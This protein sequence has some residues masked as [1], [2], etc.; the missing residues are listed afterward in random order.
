MEVGSDASS[1]WNARAIDMLWLGR[2]GKPEVSASDVELGAR[3]SR[4]RSEL[5]QAIRQGEDDDAFR[6]A[7]Q[8]VEHRLE[9][10]ERRAI[11][12]AGSSAV[13][14]DKDE[15]L[16]AVQEVEA[17]LCLV[18]PAELLYA[19]WIRLRENL[20]RFDDRRKKAW[21]DDISPWFD[22]KS[23]ELDAPALTSPLRQQLCQLTLE[24]RESA[25]RFSRLAEERA[26]VWRE[27][28]NRGV[29]LILLF[30]AVLALCLT[31]S[32]CV[33]AGKLG[34]FVFLLTGISTGGMG[35]VLSRLAYR[36]ERVRE[37]YKGV[38]KSDLLL[39]VAIGS[40]AALV[41]TAVLLSNKFFLLPE[42][43][44]AQAAYLAVI[45]FGAGFSDRFWKNMLKDVLPTSGRGTSRGGT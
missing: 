18:K 7:L 20:Y 3:L 1:S 45:G 10:A 6:G 19:T 34:T 15:C 26:A 14:S 40:G 13:E 44:L 5:T 38:F 41:V 23:G 8:E 32:T 17:Q 25:S 33:D 29:L 12:L 16:R 27:V 31:L 9:E 4:L 30:G 28:I 2:S 43:R 35:A 22:S 42:E 11:E 36:Q 21:E 39:H 24:L 37:E